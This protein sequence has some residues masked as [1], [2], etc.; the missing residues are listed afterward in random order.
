MLGYH[1]KDGNLNDN[2]NP[3]YDGNPN[4]IKRWH[5]NAKSHAAFCCQLTRDLRLRFEMFTEN[6]ILLEEHSPIHRHKNIQTLKNYHIKNKHI[7]VWKF[8]W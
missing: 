4:R 8:G 7:L 5:L 1:L 6:N 2:D 3:E